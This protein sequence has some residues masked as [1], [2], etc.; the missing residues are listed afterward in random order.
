MFLVGRGYFM[1][2][3]VNWRRG[4]PARC[5]YYAGVNPTQPVDEHPPSPFH[6]AGRGRAR[7]CKREL[8][9]PLMPNCLASVSACC[10]RPISFCP[11]THLV[12][13]AIVWPLMLWLWL[14]PPPPVVRPAGGGCGRGGGQRRSRLRYILNAWDGTGRWPSP[15]SCGGGACPLFLGTGCGRGRRSILTTVTLLIGTRPGPFW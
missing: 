3:C 5:A 6:G 8:A 1:P 7:P 2:I 10:G 12:P 11:R 4:N 9:L 13:Y 15:S 14:V